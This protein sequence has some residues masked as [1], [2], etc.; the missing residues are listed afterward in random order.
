MIRGRV[1]WYSANLGYGFIV[2]EDGSTEAF[3]RREDIARGDGFEDFENGTVV[4]YEAVQSSEGL[5]ARKV[6]R[7]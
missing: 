7:I 3:M 2:S 6:S 5:E 4:T 1:K